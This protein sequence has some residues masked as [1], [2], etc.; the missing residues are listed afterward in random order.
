MALKDF[1]PSKIINFTYHSTE[2]RTPQNFED[3]HS[4]TVVSGQR[5]KIEEQFMAAGK[6]L[7]EASAYDINTDPPAAQSFEANNTTVTG[8][9]DLIVEKFLE[10]DPLTSKTGATVYDDTIGSKPDNTQEFVANGYQITGNKNKIENLLNAADDTLGLLNAGGFTGDITEFQNSLGGYGQVLDQVTGEPQTYTITNNAGQY[11]ITGLK[12]STTFDDLDDLKSKSII[13]SALDNAVENN[14][15]RSWAAP[16]TNSAEKGWRQI[17]IGI[18]DFGSGELDSGPQRLGGNTT[19]PGFTVYPINPSWVGPITENYTDI[20]TT[21]SFYGR[22]T[23]KLLGLAEDQIMAGDDKVFGNLFTQVDILGL[24]AGFVPGVRGITFGSAFGGKPQYTKHT[25]IYGLNTTDGLEAETVESGQFS[26]DSDFDE[27]TMPK[28][29][30]LYDKFILGSET[31]PDPHLTAQTFEQGHLG[32]SADQLNNASAVAT[33][34]ANFVLNWA[35][36]AFNK[37]YPIIPTQ[38]YTNMLGSGTNYIS[39]TDTRYYAKTTDVPTND[40]SRTVPILTSAVIDGD[41]TPFIGNQFINEEGGINE[42]ASDTDLRNQPR[43]ANLYKKIILD[44]EQILGEQYEKIFKGSNNKYNTP[45]SSVISQHPQ[46]NTTQ[47]R[48]FTDGQKYVSQKVKPRTYLNDKQNIEGG[49]NPFQFYSKHSTTNL[50]YD[51]NNDKDLI[52]KFDANEFKSNDV[53]KDRIAGVSGS[54][55]HT[56]S[57][58]SKLTDAKP[59]DVSGR[60]AIKDLANDGEVLGKIPIISRD[61]LTPESASSLPYSQLG[62]SMA[63]RKILLSPSEFSVDGPQT[64]EGLVEIDNGEAKSDGTGLRNDGR[65]KIYQIGKTG[66]HR[67]SLYTPKQ[68]DFLGYVKKDGENYV[69]EEVDK[70]NIITY[71]NSMDGGDV[72]P[73]DNLDFVPLVFQDVYNEKDIVFRAILGSIED[74]HTP[75]WEET[76]FVGRPKKSYTYKG[77]DRELSFDFKVYPKTK[78]EFPVLL[79][80]I[81]YLSGLAYPNLDKYYRMAGPLCKLTLGD[82]C[83]RQLGFLSDIGVTFPEDSTWET[84]KGLRF[85]KLINVTISFKYIGGYIPVSTGKHYELDWLNGTDYTSEGV[86]FGS[87]EVTR[88]SDQ[89][90]TI[91]DNASQIG[92]V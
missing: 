13:I 38:N 63:Y 20:V 47:G 53:F 39:H 90:N 22:F 91:V 17:P 79:E 89:M 60:L 16:N 33:A 15:M 44:G 52:S 11:N 28:M 61:K 86:A 14:T 59:D 83:K 87:D 76:S 35:L 81:N 9:R 37:K 4:G 49:D 82:I 46:G 78:Q 43:L 42:E 8:V 54:L 24:G 23:S 21:N 32:F 77:V 45:N 10:G 12:G 72:S 57:I 36:D 67:T 88:N 92:T 51:A 58:L 68:D 6:T 41:N 71:R 34:G 55:D 70:V 50:R 18:R 75:D 62:D 31:V 84:Q 27:Q 5:D 19:L 2:T 73:Y 3:G 26:G 48:K 29:M 40:S 85:T 64:K 30:Y 69:T 1:D 65:N 80:K 74:K 66:F 7:Q 56:K 25:S